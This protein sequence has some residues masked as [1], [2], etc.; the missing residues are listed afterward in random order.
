MTN[1]LETFVN[2]AYLT[3]TYKKFFAKNLRINEIGYDN[4]FDQGYFDNATNYSS[5]EGFG[6]RL[7][8]GEDFRNDEILGDF[9]TNNYVT[10]TEK[11]MRLMKIGKLMMMI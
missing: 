4:F 3:L 10:Y 9:I 2:K 8:R 1:Y 5:V 7:T 11:N 6:V